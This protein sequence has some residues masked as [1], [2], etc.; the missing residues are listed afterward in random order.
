MPLI[1]LLVGSHFHPP[2]K[3][4]LEHLPVGT[5]VRLRPEPDNPYD[6]LAIQVL[7]DPRNIPES[8]FDELELALPGM[9][10][11]MESLLAQD[12]ILLG[13]S[14]KSGGKPIIE[15]GDPECVGNSE[16]FEV[17]GPFER[18]E[19]ALLFDGGKYPLIRLREIG[20]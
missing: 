19:G 6:P 10:S 13:H 8:Q 20:D 14:A 17:F 2:A 12:F 3:L 18:L 7:L 4:L 5:P 11:D 15:R 9:G 1:T 16:I